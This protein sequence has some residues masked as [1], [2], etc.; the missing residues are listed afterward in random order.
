MRSIAFVTTLFFLS[1]CGSGGDKDTTLVKPAFIHNV[2]FYFNDT[3]NVQLADDFM[4]G[5]D[6]LATVSAIHK[7][8]YGPPAMTQR[9]VVDNSYDYAYLVEFLS[10][11]DHE[12]YQKDSIHLEFVDKYKSLWKEVKVY[13]NIVHNQIRK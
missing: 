7:V 3:V 2:Y 6:T 12:S 4:N 13:D 10:E 1:A 9:E 11:D 8:T 5:L